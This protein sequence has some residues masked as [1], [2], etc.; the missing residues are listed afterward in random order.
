MQE[1]L[2]SPIATDKNPFATHRRTVRRDTTA[3]EIHRD[4]KLSPQCQNPENFSISTIKL[5][6]PIAVNLCKIRKINGRFM[7][8]TFGFFIIDNKFGFEILP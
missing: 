2:L 8:S 7:I 5:Q 3:H 6:T 1:S 4:V